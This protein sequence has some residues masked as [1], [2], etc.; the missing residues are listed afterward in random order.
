MSSEACLSP[1]ASKS[2]GEGGGGLSRLDAR[3]L[4]DPLYQLIVNAETQEGSV[5]VLCDLPRSSQGADTQRL[6]G[7]L[8]ARSRPLLMGSLFHPQELPLERVCVSFSPV[9]FEEARHGRCGCVAT[10]SPTGRCTGDACEGI[11]I[12]H[13]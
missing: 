6:T 13:S 12:M 5:Q 4:F 10:G 3:C 1:K 11:V 2:K 9:R 8:P 7:T